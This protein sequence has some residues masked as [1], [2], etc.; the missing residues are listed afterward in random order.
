MP[1]GSF[2]EPER[3]VIRARDGLAIPVTLWRPAAATGKRGGRTVPTIVHAHGGPSWQVL[4]DFQPFRQLLV[5][6]GFAFLSVDFRGST[7]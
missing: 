7:G 4:R 2:V 5:Q 1:V 6:E 3:L